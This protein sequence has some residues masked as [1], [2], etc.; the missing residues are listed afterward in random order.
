MHQKTIPSVSLYSWLCL[1]AVTG[2]GALPDA[3]GQGCMA[4]RVS[5]PMLGASDDSRYLKPGEWESSLSFRH[6]ESS[7]HFHDYNQENVPANAPQVMRT[8]AD[9]SLTTALTNIDSLTL[10]IPYQWGHFD[11]SPIP[12]YTGSADTASGIGD[13]ALTFRRWLL[14]RHVHTKG[15][16]R[17][18]LGVKFPTGDYD[19]ETNRLVNTAPQGGP[20]NLVWRRG[21]ADVAVQPGDGGWGIILGLESFYQLTPSVMLYEEVTY[22]ANPR[23]NNGTNN[24]WSGAGPYV[25]NPVT[26]VPD[27][28]LGRAGFAIGNPLGWSGGSF[29]LGMRAEGQPVRDLI[30]SNSGFRRPGASI[31]V[32]PGIGYGFGKWSVFASV[33]ITVYRFRWRSVDEK[34]AGYNNAVSAAFADYNFIAGVTRRW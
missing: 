34:K 3:A 32:E 21:P 10:S 12:P 23:G 16:I 33:P 8:V 1:L 27:Y 13:V 9:L 20:Q 28:F 14:D 7:R 31:S 30:G 29:Q 24:Q 26:S 5:P 11:R 2:I 4:T 22:L 19:Q 18:G 6:Y 15:N 17:V 25:P